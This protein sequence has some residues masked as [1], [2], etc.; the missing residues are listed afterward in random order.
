MVVGK[1]LSFEEGLFSGAML[2][3]ASLIAGLLMIS[4]SN[5]LQ[6]RVCFPK[7]IMATEKVQKQVPC[8][9]LFQEEILVMEET[10]QHIGIHETLQIEV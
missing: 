3:L 2:V 1:L 4:P 10:L 9:I 6:D 7:S 8:C 5:L